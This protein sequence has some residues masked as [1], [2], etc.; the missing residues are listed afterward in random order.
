[1]KFEITTVHKLKTEIAT[2]IALLGFSAK[3]ADLVKLQNLLNE[4]SDDLKC[5]IEMPYTDKLYR[6]SYYFYFATKFQEFSRDTIRICL[7]E[8][9]FSESIFINGNADDIQKAF[10]GFFILRPIQGKYLGRTMISPRAFKSQHFVSC[11]ARERV[12]LAG[13]NLFVDAFPHSSQDTSTISCAETSIWMIMEYFSHRYPEYSPV[14]P[15]KIHQILLD[16]YRQRSLPSNGLTAIQI[17]SALR[18]LGFGTVMYTKNKNNPDELLQIISTYVES[19]I[20]TIVATRSPQKAGHALVAIGHDEK[21]DSFDFESLPEKSGVFDTANLKRNFIF[22]DDNRPIYVSSSLKEPLAGYNGD[23]L[24]KSTIEAA[25]V[26]LYPKIFLEAR[27]ARKLFEGIFKLRDF[28]SRQKT[29]EVLYR[30]IF[31]TSGRSYKHWLRKERIF[32]ENLRNIILQTDLPKFIWLSEYG[33][34]DNYRSMQAGS[35]ICLDA[36]GDQ[37]LSSLIF[38]IY[39][40]RYVVLDNESRKYKGEKVALPVFPLYQNNLKG[41][42]NQWQSN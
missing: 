2:V 15:S 12:S 14:L 39:P 25:I 18:T 9:N 22:S 4:F 32:D 36:T 29:D 24:P 34:A 33:T 20:P 37:H 38:S 1:M 5:F 10:L 26:P 28:G 13:F 31:L 16:T 41:E 27:G 30:R 40:D 7:F 6:D 8:K 21:T 19:G 11:L 42:W 23:D 35:I 3:E 17:S